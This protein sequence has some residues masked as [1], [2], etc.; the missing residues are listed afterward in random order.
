MCVT[1]FRF[2]ARGKFELP[3]SEIKLILDLEDNTGLI[4]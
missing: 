4:L 2:G 1:S 3:S